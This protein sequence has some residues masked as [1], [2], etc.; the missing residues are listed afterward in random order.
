M[1]APLESPECGL[2]NGGKVSILI[3]HF[4]AQNGRAPG[5]PIIEGD[6]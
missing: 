4:D 6:T 3:L 1:L 2:S 5:S